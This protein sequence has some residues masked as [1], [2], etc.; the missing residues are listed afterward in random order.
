[1]SHTH[2]TPVPAVSTADKSQ[3]IFPL[4][5]AND[6]YSK[7]E[8]DKEATATCFCGRVQLAFVSCRST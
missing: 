7:S 8:G 3:P 4:T 1:M 2:T 5:I 6:G